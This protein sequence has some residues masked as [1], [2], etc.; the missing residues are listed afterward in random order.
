MRPNRVAFFRRRVC[1]AQCYTHT[2]HSALFDERPYL[3]WQSR[4]RLQGLVQQAATIDCGEKM[5]VT[6][7]V[8]LIL[9]TATQKKRDKLL[10][11]HWYKG[12]SVQFFFSNSSPSTRRY[13]SASMAAWK[14]FPAPVGPRSSTRGVCGAADLCLTDRKPT[15]VAKPQN[16]KTTE[17]KSQSDGQLTHKHIRAKKWSRGSHYLFGS[18]TMGTFLGLATQP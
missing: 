13:L 14:L 12:C 10:Q 9:S 16:A 17:H 15:T 5:E 6:N 3:V 8:H 4:P 1:L 11:N 2:L 7:T 18:I